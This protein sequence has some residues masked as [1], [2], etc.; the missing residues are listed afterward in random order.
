MPLLASGEQARTGK[1]RRGLW[2]LPVLLAPVLV[3]VFIGMPC[4]GVRLRLPERWTLYA[5]CVDRP[6]T[7][8]W[9][10]L[11]TPGPGLS[12]A[13]PNGW[14]DRYSLRV[15]PFVYAA[16]HGDGGIIY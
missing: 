1:P 6:S 15:G 16:Y 2:A 5:W 10:G 3:L 8:P 14:D 9:I 7:L 12:V 4:A 11:E 13:H